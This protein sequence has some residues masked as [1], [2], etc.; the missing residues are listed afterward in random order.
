MATEQEIDSTG[1]ILL[2]SLL[3]DYAGAEQEIILIGA[4]DH[5]EV[6]DAKKWEEHRSE[7]LSDF[8]DLAEELEGL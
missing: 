5:I 1:R 8:S 2:P 4:E 6:W 7:V 3:R